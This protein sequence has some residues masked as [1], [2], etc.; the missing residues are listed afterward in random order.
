MPKQKSSGPMSSAGLMQYYDADK[1]AIHID[2]K[3]VVATGILLG[4]L[5]LGLNFS[6]GLWP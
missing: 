4:V 5:V 3:I 6:F 1:K 2:P